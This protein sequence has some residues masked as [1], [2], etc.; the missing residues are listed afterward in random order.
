MKVNVDIGMIDGESKRGIERYF[1]KSAFKQRKSYDEY[2][3]DVRDIEIDLDLSD[4]VEMS[5][6]VQVSVACGELYLEV[7]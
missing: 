6:Y 4:L 2:Y 5:H 7:N 1:D 3:F